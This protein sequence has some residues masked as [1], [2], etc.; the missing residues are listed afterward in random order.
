MKKEEE[1]GKVGG[2]RYVKTCVRVKKVADRHSLRC[3]VS[4]D[5]KPKKPVS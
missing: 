3:C 2:R 4:L 5:R 1:E